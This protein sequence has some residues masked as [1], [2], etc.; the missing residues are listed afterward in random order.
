[1]QVGIYDD[2]PLPTDPSQLLQHDAIGG[3]ILTD[4]HIVRGIGY[5]TCLV[6]PFYLFFFIFL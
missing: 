3:D 6:V 5:V 1:M 4:V 2:V